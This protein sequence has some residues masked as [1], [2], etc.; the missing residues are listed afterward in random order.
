MFYA[1]PEKADENCDTTLKKFFVKELGVT[2]DVELAR[3]HRMGKHK[4]A[5]TRPIVAK[6]HR[7]QQRETIRSAGPRLAG[8]KIG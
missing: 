5:K 7:Y 4:P 1:I 6:S 8:E 3:A 2:E